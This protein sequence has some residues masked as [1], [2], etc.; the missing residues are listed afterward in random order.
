MYLRCFASERH[1]K[2]VQWLPLAKWWYNTTYH[3]TTKMTPY[4]EVYGK[5]PP[6]L[7][8]YLQGP[9]KVQVVETLR[10]QR[11]WTLVTLKDNLAMA[12]NRMK[13]QADQ[14]RSKRSFEVGDLVF[15]R[16]HPYLQTYLKY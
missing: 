9:S 12:Q 10:Q 4:G 3:A 7:T 16:L 6:S 14:H 8:S 5:Q 2:W 1:H 13:Q 11:D 15:L